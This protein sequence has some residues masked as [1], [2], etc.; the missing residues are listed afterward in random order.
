MKDLAVS[1]R[2][3]RLCEES[4][5]RRGLVP[6]FRGVYASSRALGEGGPPWVARQRVAEA[7][8]LAIHAK[9]HGGIE[10]AFTGESALVA[11]GI[12]PWW[13]NPDVFVRRNPR[14]GS[15]RVVP[16]VAL[17]NTTVSEVRV[18][19]TSMLPRTLEDSTRTPQGLPV[20][21]DYMVAL[22]LARVFH[23][24]QA[25]HD[26]S[27]LMRWRVQFD[28]R[29]LAPS[30]KRESDYKAKLTN[31]LEALALDGQRAPAGLRQAMALVSCADP[32]IESPAESIV[33]WALHSILRPGEII[34]TQTPVTAHGRSRN[35]DITLPKYRVAIETT[36]LGKYGDTS[37]SAHAVATAAVIRQQELEDVDWRFINVAYEQTL[38]LAR[39][40]AYLVE[41][42]SRFN[43]PTRPPGGTCFKRPTRELFA[44]ERRY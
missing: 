18:R 1:T 19:Q 8:L 39:L 24:L 6:I 3:A 4:A 43:V 38:N 30:R 9:T 31:Q 28:R 20:A 10:L 41:R 27:Q 13:N 16:R 11:R 23:P 25:F 37:T 5:N 15:V 33:L 29:S 44:R 2:E 42:L 35:L 7:R 32:G 17:E 36:G 40:A 34:E 14:S 12:E 21:P 26:L 22:D